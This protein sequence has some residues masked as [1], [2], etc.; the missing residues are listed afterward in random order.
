[1]TNRFIVAAIQ[2]L[3]PKYKL[4]VLLQIAEMARSTYYYTLSAIR[5]PDKYSD[6]R[7]KLN[8]LHVEHQ[9]RYGYRR[10]TS[11]LRKEGITLN[12]KTV[13]RLMK[14]ES[15]ECKI[16]RKRKKYFNPSQE[17]EA[18][19]NVL[20]RDFTATEPYKKA[21]TDVTEFW[22]KN[23]K[24]YVSVLIDLY[25][26]AVISTS[27]ST[28]NNTNLIINMFD[29]IPNDKKACMVN[30]L[31][32]SDQGILYRTNRYHNFVNANNIIQ[33]MS[34]RGNCYDNAVAES[35]F[36]TFKSEV[37]YIKDIPSV[38]VFK[39]EFE[40]YI[41]YYNYDRIKS[42]LGYLSPMQYRKMNGY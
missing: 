12:H 7:V 22:I 2:S 29:R 15:I 18:S 16:R 23:T 35:F 24:I 39:Q 27:F 9:G 20:N 32:H 40:E 30:M 11:E 28:S 37:L 21:V 19:P 5:K 38:E 31:I 17:L 41:H 25:D 42:K 36:G 10:L 4:S 13:S 3:E 26:G 14:E 33:S 1:M 6:A 8:E 34:R